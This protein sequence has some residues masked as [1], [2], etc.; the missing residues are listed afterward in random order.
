MASSGHASGGGRDRIVGGRCTGVSNVDDLF[1]RLEAMARTPG[2]DRGEMA[3]VVHALRSEVGAAR[4][5]ADDLAQAQAEAIVNAGMMMSELQE[6]QAQLEKARSAAEAADRAKSEFL[7]HM[8]HEIRTPFNGVLG[9]AEILLKSALSPQQ[10]HCA[11]TIQESA[12]A[13]LSVI[14]D[15]LD[16]SK[17]E[18]GKLFIQA[19]EFNL[20]DTVEAVAHALAERA[21]RKRLEL[22]CRIPHDIP[23]RWI[24]DAVRLRQVLTNLLGN[25]VKF[26]DSGETS[27]SVRVLEAAG[28]GNRR[29]RFDV[30]DTG[31]GIDAQAQRRVFEA[32]A[33]AD[34]RS[35]RQ[36]EG[37]GLGLAISAHLV[38]LMGG[39][40]RLESTPGRGSRFWF[41]IEL[42]AV[43]EA[44]GR[45]A[46]PDRVI[47]AGRRVLVVDDNRTNLEICAEQLSGLALHTL[48]VGDG[49]EALAALRLCR[50]RG[51]PF[52]L[53]ILDM[54]MPAMNG[55]DVARAIQADDALRTVPRILLSSV[56]DSE[57]AHTLE[58][59]GIARAITKPVRQAELL[60]YVLAVLGRP[61]APRTVAPLP[62]PQASLAGRVLVAEDNGVNQ[63][64]ARAMLRSLGLECEIAVNGMAAL[65]AWQQGGF[66][67]VLMDC[68][69]PVLDGYEAT[70]RIRDEEASRGLARVAVVALTANVVSGVRERCEAAGMDAYLS[71]PYSE[72]ALAQVL[73]RWLPHHGAVARD[74]THEA[75]PA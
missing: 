41:E 73:A 38:A 69:M 24:G 66:D 71:K 9:M 70:R 74:G 6:A 7:A 50:E 18:A 4:R 22:L 48:C 42:Q 31:I 34:H 20:R 1:S 53:V 72:R 65:Q 10:R 32:F 47:A 28:N 29:L 44:Q 54:H 60:E 25:A 52:D 17:I 61:G 37:T 68:E 39:E 16:F 51:E 56:G 23:A 64:V 67:L 63:L 27:I 33:Q 13:L 46:C 5:R 21:H 58:A 49:G 8:S 36:Y 45:Q 40:L 43:D 35:Q 14:N 3:A 2:G 26:T 15:I 19:Y 12:S 59:A 57:P 11:L 75:P 55:L 30:A 62:A